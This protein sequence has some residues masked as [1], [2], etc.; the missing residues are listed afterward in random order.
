MIPVHWYKYNLTRDLSSKEH[1][2]SFYK[3]MADNDANNYTVN[4]LYK[5]HVLA[6]YY[7]SL[8]TRGQIKFANQNALFHVMGNANFIK[9]PDCSKIYTDLIAAMNHI[10]NIKEDLIKERRKRYAGHNYHGPISEKQKKQISQA[11]RGRV[12]I[13]KIIGERIVVKS[14]KQDSLK[15]YLDSG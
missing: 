10:E 12:Y 7:L 15:A 2:Y 3:K 11:N 5:D 4:L 8:C 9:D 6:H 14:I 13:R 1:N